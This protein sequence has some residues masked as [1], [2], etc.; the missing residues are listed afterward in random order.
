MQAEACLVLSRRQPVGW[1][2]TMTDLVTRTLSP[3]LERGVRTLLE[4]AFEGGFAETDWAHAQGGHH[5]LVLEGERVLA[6][7]AVVER[8]LY[9]GGRGRSAG[10]VEAV[11]VHPEW[12]RLG[13]G[14]RVMG[15]LAPVLTRWELCAL[16]TGQHGFYGGLG[17]QRWRGPTWIHTSSGRQ[18]SPDEDDGVMVLGGAGDRT[19]SLGCDDRPG[20]AW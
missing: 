7:A 6:H 16:S 3:A 18:R 8:T 2:R 10:Y 17:W 1:A 14:T 9:V 4:L 13:L 12:Q 15:Q 19:R 20:D 5:A 11:A